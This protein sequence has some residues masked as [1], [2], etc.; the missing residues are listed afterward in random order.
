MSTK[1]P[2]APFFNFLNRTNKNE[3]FEFLESNLSLGENGAG[4]YRITNVE[5]IHCSLESTQTPWHTEKEFL[6]ILEEFCDDEEDFKTTQKYCSERIQILNDSGKHR[7]LDDQLFHPA[8]DRTALKINN[9][10]AFAPNENFAQTAAQSEVYF[11]ISSIL[12]DLRNKETLLQSEYVRNLLDPGNFVRYNDGI[13]Q[14]CILR[15]AKD[16]ELKF[17]LS[18]ELSL[19]MKSIIGDMILHLE[20]PHS[21]AL[22]E[23]FYAIA[24]KKLRLVERDLEDCIK[25][26]EEQP[27][28]SEGDSILKGMIAYIRKKVLSNRDIKAIFNDLPKVKVEG[29]TREEI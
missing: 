3:F 17:H 18:D 15:A 22:I 21:E 23:F 19:Q 10:F 6:T 26:L 2:S 7:G 13:I 12:N 25:L 1:K 29:E 20:D 24:I 28:Y 14:A 9:G 27:S 5:K 11:I 16:Y 8:F 4:T